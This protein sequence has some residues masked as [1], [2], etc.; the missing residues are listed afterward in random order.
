MVFPFT[1]KSKSYSDC[2]RDDDSE[3]HLWCATTANYDEDKKWGYCTRHLIYAVGGTAKGEPCVFPFKYKSKWYPDCTSDDSSEGRLWCATTSDYEKDKKWGYCTRNLISAVGGNS[4]GQP[5]VFP[6]KYNDKWYS[7][8]TN[9]GISSTRF[10]CAT[11][12]DF[13]KDQKWGYCSVY[14]AHNC[15]PTDDALNSEPGIAPEGNACETSAPN[16]FLTQQH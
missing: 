5:C 7:D 1:Y 9:D 15:E 13:N 12:A 14:D 10:W 4:D 16:I 6:F 2:T 11:T 3:G 8:C